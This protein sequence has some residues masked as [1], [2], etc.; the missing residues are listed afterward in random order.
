MDETGKDDAS[1]LRQPGLEYAVHNISQSFTLA[2]SVTIAG[3]HPGFHRRLP[4]EGW[5]KN[6]SGTWIGPC[7][8]FHT[9]GMKTPVDVL[10]LDRRFIVCRLLPHLKPG[11]VFVC[12][13]AA[14]VL[15]LEA[16]AISRTG[17]KVGDHLLFETV[18]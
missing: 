16:G 10:F 18:C 7:D 6:G 8:A 14:S 3:A 17:T 11:R 5:P 13:A 9:F 1:R 4:G 15:K 12:L 2:R